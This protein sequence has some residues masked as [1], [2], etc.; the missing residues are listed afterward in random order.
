MKK[1]DKELIKESYDYLKDLC[2]YLS[3][4]YEYEF[5]APATEEEIKNWEKENKI[6]I[7]SMFREWLLLTKNC[8][9]ANRSWR[10]FWPEIDETVNVL[11]G[12]FIGDGEYLYFSKETGVFFTL[13]EGDEEDFD[14]FDSVLTY[15][16]VDLEDK[17]EEIFGEDWLEEFENQYN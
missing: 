4:E 16:S 8:N 6:N 10:L 1:S 5:E 2:D 9:M 13:F 17:A 15:I 3:D 14:S 12:S 11:V 7:P